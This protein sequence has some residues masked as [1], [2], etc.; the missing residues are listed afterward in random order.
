M[1]EVLQALPKTTNANFDSAFVKDTLVF[2]V[3]NIGWGG[4]TPFMTSLVCIIHFDLSVKLT[5][6]TRKPERAE[7]ISLSICTGS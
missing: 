4:L 1:A 7:T 2:G 5:D 3:S 6:H